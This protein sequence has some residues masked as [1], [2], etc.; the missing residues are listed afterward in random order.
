MSFLGVKQVKEADARLCRYFL[1]SPS[2]T[3]RWP[4]SILP[5]PG[6]RGSAS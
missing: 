2:I 6:S 3:H 1:I 5:L 4:S